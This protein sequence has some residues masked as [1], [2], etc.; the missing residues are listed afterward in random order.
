MQPQPSAADRG[1]TL[2]LSVGLLLAV[3]GFAMV[4]TGMAYR[5]AA[6]DFTPDGGSQIRSQAPVR[7]AVVGRPVGIWMAPGSPLLAG[8]RGN[9]RRPQDQLYRRRA[10][11]PN[12]V[13][14]DRQRDRRADLMDMA[15]SIRWHRGAASGLPPGSD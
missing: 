4:L 3:F 5:T 7:S 14:V 15:V 1:V 12:P 10:A 2:A 11:T 6:G 13:L 8:Q 9:R